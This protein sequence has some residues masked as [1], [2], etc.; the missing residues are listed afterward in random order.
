[1]SRLSPY[2][3]DVRLRTVRAIVWVTAGIIVVAYFRTQIVDHGKYEGES[4][5]NR[6]RPITLPAPR[7]I[8]TDRHGIV[9]AENVPGYTVS[10]IPAA[11]STMRATLRTIAPLVHLDAAAI[12]R[13]IGRASCRERV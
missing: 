13:E 1:M 3:L 5:N 7:G 4:L 12:E 2:Q 10:L 9:I 11:E 8:I 6:L